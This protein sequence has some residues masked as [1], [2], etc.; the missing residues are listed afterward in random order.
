[1]KKLISLILAMACLVLMLAGCGCEHEWKDANC[2]DPM[3]CGL[4]GETEGEALG[5][6]PGDMAVTQEPV[7]GKAGLREQSC[8]V[9]GEV[10]GTEEYTLSATHDGTN[11][12]LTVTEYSARLDNILRQVR[13]GL[14]CR[15]ENNKNGNPTI[16][17]FWQEEG[18]L[19][20]IV[21]TTAGEDPLT[22]AAQ[23]PGKMQNLMQLNT[24]QQTA[25]EDP[26]PVYEL[27][28]DVL[29]A[30]IMACDPQISGADARKIVTDFLDSGEMYV[31]ENH[32][33]LEYYFFLSVFGQPILNLTLT[34]V[35]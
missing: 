19:T 12:T 3:T 27:Q 23:C 22:D 35:A 16:Y 32:G 5:H 14:S 31:M 8:T 9:C 28:L 34:P 26:I 33:T 4:C 10:V 13:D 2:T 17:V 21:P 20:A 24:T 7:E 15:I 30:M 18:Y 1:M 6:T 11:Y 29:Q 25:G